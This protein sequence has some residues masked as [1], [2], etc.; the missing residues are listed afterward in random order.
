MHMSIRDVK[1][2]PLD[3]Q[4]SFVKSEARRLKKNP[5][6]SLIGKR[7]KFILNIVAQKLGFSSYDDLYAKTKKIREESLIILKNESMLRMADQSRTYYYFSMN[8]RS[9]YSYYSHWVAYD[10]DGYELREASLVNPEFFMDFVRNE[11]SQPL[12]IVHNAKE[13]CS[14]MVLWRG[15]ALIDSKLMKKEFPTMLG[16]S[17][18]WSRPRLKNE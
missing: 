8:Q 13:L 16:P 6:P 2:L 17:R 4:L 15:Q 7:H 3:K 5:P 9:T 14:W 11:M 18:S 1:S 10:D 12:Y